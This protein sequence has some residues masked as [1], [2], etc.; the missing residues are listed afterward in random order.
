MEARVFHFEKWEVFKAA[1]RL[2]EIAQELSDRM[3][4]GFGS[5]LRHLREASSSVVLNLAEGARQRSP[6]RRLDMYSIALG[7]TSECYG[8]FL[9]LARCARHEPLIAEGKYECNRI[10]PMI[11]N[12]IRNKDR[13]PGEADG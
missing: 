1:L 8:V 9:I 11:T 2:R 10:A 12:L 6:G 4:R 3:P 5:E 7:S 13:P